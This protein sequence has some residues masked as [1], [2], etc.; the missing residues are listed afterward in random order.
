[1]PRP[2]HYQTRPKRTPPPPQRT[3]EPP[4]EPTPEPDPKI[5]LDHI[6]EVSKN[7][8]ATWFG[9]LGLRA[10]VGVT[11][12]AHNDADFSPTAPRPNCR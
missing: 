5:I 11:L 1:M 2:I 7:A 3:P 12:V 10:F 9:L 8:R 6:A 4:P